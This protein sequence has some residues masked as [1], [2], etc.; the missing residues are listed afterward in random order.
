MFLY[1]RNTLYNFNRLIHK[2]YFENQSRNISL[3]LSCQKKKNITRLNRYEFYQFLKKKNYDSCSL[4][5][6]KEKGFYIMQKFLFVQTL[7]S[8]IKK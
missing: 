5:P 6:F 4:V 8:V 2:I 3:F 7:I 1:F